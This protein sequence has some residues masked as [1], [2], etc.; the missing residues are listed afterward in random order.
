VRDERGAYLLAL[1]EKDR[2]G[3]DVE[4]IRRQAE[5]AAEL[6]A[7]L[8]EIAVRLERDDVAFGRV[9]SAAKAGRRLRLVIATLSRCAERDRDLLAEPWR[10]KAEAEA[11]DIGGPNKQ[12]ESHAP[13]GVRPPFP[14]EERSRA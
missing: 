7:G 12:K 10:P 11:T 13:P 4:K 9:G 6:A 8:N 5:L 3:R 1:S 14:S 2:L